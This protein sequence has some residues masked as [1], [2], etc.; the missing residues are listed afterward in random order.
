MIN[1]SR[2]QKIA[3]ARVLTDLIEADFVVEPDEMCF[4]EQIISKDGFSITNAMLIE[5]KK[6]DLAKAVSIL[7]QLDEKRSSLVLD[8]LKKLSMSDGTCV[9]SEAILIFAVEQVLRYGAKIY[10]VPSSNVRID[11]LKVIY[12]ENESGTIIADQIEKNLFSIMGEMKLAGFDFV[13]IPKIVNDYRLMEREYLHKVVK[14]MIPPITDERIAEICE[15]LSELTTAR[16]CRDLLYK[17]IGVNLIGC[18]PSLLIKINDSDIIDYNGIDSADRIRFCNYLQLDL[19]D[20]VMT[21][22]RRMVDTYYK[23]INCSVMVENKPHIAKFIYSGFH[24]SLFDLIAYE[25]ELRECRLVIDVSTH[26]SSVYFETLENEQERIS[27]KLN[28]QETALYFMIVSKSLSSDG[29]DW[30]EH[31]PKAQKQEILAEYNRIYGNIGKSNTVTEYKDRTQVH[32]IKNRI[33][34]LL[35]IANKEMFIPEHVKDE[36]SSFY[37]IRADEKYV[38]LINSTL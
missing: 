1:L 27:L 14:Y 10:S 9:P 7:K 25:R 26:K 36:K 35:S 23:M 33:R 31:I 38:K 13:Y 24:R 22:V 20:D 4:F 6:V 17:K 37:R 8:T 29:L 34:A 30:R 19:C 5:A 28:P 3:F 12:V 18:R 2:E 11:N 16:F 15:N 21:V 32:H